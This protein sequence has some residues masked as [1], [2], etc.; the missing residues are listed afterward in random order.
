MSIGHLSSNKNN[1]SR[2]L[3]KFIKNITQTKSDITTN[4]ANTALG[5]SGIRKSALFYSLGFRFSHTLRNIC[6]TVIVLQMAQKSHPI[7]HDILNYQVSSTFTTSN[8]VFIIRSQHLFNF[9]FLFAI[10]DIKCILVPCALVGCYPILNIRVLIDKVRVKRQL[11]RPNDQICLPRLRYQ[12]HFIVS[13]KYL[14]MQYQQLNFPTR[15]LLWIFG[16]EYMVY[17]IFRMTY[18]Q[19][20]LLFRLKVQSRQVALSFFNV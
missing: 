19:I 4:Y 9:R 8:Y 14:L 13:S 18:P 12:L 2:R 3:Y 17:S 1:S 7:V 20:F 5:H 11:R 15:N 6:N 10:P 16:L